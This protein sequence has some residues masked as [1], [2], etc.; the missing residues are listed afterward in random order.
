MKICQ[1]RGSRGKLNT[2]EFYDSLEFLAG[3]KGFCHSPTFAALQ[4]LLQKSAIYGIQYYRSFYSPAGWWKTFKCLWNPATYG[5][6]QYSKPKLCG[7]IFSNCNMRWQMATEHRQIDWTLTFVFPKGM[8][9]LERLKEE[10]FRRQRNL[11]HKQA[12]RS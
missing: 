1:C 8:N 10:L 3:S 4:S 11:K 7:L 2:S 5:R 9:G 12:A 6:I